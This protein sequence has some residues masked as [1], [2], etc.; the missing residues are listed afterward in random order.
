MEDLN[1]LFVKLLED[2]VWENHLGQRLEVEKEVLLFKRK[3]IVHNKN[4]F[5]LL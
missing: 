4:V 1:A 5:D 3:L 2:R